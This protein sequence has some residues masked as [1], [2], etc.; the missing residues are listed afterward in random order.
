MQKI[1]ILTD[2]S[3]DL[4]QDELKQDNLFLL[5]LRI[6]Y[7]DGEFLDKINITPK[8]V[9][10]R[11]PSETPTTSLVCPEHINEV[12][13][14]IESEGYTHVIGIFV[15]E[16]LSGT[17]NAVRLVIEERTNFTYTLFNSKII[18]YPLGRIVNNACD[19]AKEGKS[20]EDI[21]EKLP[22]I[23]DNIT[24]Y[25]TVD[26]LEYLRRGGRIGK[27]AGAVGDLLHL[28][29][30]ITMDNEGLYTSVAKVR[31]RKQSLNKI[32]NL[33]LEHL[34]KEPCSVWLLNGNA[35]KE[36]IDILESI[37]SHPNLLKSGLEEIGAAM[38]VHSGPGMV[39]VAIQK[40]F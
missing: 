17:F 18:G 4:N 35:E 16:A 24:G 23:R 27:V 7:S 6:I 34:D 22:E 14:R 26:T 30:I 33:I 5:P 40:G 12:L 32:K 29:P 3:C 1:A 21:L 39:G 38:G 20:Y 10:D 36:A 37:K 9:F 15:S 19:L 28:K 8:E 25:Y 11:L 2:S 13:D 31:G